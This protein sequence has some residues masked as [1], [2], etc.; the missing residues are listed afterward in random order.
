MIKHLTS[1]KPTK[2][3]K[4]NLKIILISTVGEI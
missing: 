3:Q 2:R 4:D 1:K